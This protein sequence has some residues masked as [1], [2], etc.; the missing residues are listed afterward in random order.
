[1]GFSCLS[2]GSQIIPP[3]LALRGSRPSG[4][5]LGGCP[6]WARRRARAPRRSLPPLPAACLPPLT[7]PLRRCAVLP[8]GAWLGITPPPTRR[9][10]S[11]SRSAAVDPGCPAVVA[12][13]PL[14]R[15][16]FLFSRRCFVSSRSLVVFAGSRGLGSSSLS[17]VSPVVRAVLRAGFGV[18]VGCSRDADALVLSA[19]F[20]VGGLPS[21]LSVFAVGGSSGRGFWRGSA[22]ALV[23]RAASAG[24]RLFWCSGGPLSFSLPRRLR[25]RSCA[26]VRSA[27]AVAAAGGRGAFVA[28]TSSEF[29]GQ[30]WQFPKGGFSRS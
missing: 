23:R 2:P 24:A 16:L 18:S 21:D 19:F 14:L 1:M 20:A 12:G 13:C 4:S 10:G 30:M 11:G 9:R 8:P 3:G 17:L 6:S 5:A 28:C 15:G 29:L 22:L 7:L 27:G 25:S 26:C